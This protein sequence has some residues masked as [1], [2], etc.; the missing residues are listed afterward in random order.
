M[1]TTRLKEITFRVNTT[2]ALRG[3]IMILLN[4]FHTKLIN[5]YFLKQYLISKVLNVEN[6][7]P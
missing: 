2:A 7:T 3:H 4:I 6:K 1:V 5:P